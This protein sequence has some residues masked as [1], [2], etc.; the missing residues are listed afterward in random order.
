M[1]RLIYAVLLVM[2]AAISSAYGQ[3]SMPPPAATPAPLTATF[4]VNAKAIGAFSGNQEVAA[5]DIGAT[6]QLTPNFLIRTDNIV[7]ADGQVFLNG[8]Q[9]NIPLAKL[10]KSTTLNPNQFQFYVVGQAG[11]ARTSA[12]QAFSGS[13]GGGLNYDPTAGGHFGVNIFE[14]RYVTKL[15]GATQIAPGT[16]ISSGINLTF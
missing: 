1:K 15:P 12:A 11:V 16:V 13:F 2:F 3:T 7:S 14:M 9:Y 8:V 10:L 4:T 5:T 6:L